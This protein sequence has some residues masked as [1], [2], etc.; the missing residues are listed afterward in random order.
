MSGLFDLACSH[1]V[2]HVRT[3]F[4]F[5]AQYSTVCMDRSHSVYLS[6][7]D[8]HWGCLHLLAFVNNAVVNMGICIYL[9]ESLLSILLG[10]YSYLGEKLLG[11]VVILHLTFWGPTKPFHCSLNVCFSYYNWGWASCHMIGFCGVLSPWIVF[12]NCA[13]FRAGM[14]WLFL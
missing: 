14:L 11:R 10:I 2:A 3:S 7:V 12:I 9:F 8:R 4:L 5:M 6:S 1:V 13:C